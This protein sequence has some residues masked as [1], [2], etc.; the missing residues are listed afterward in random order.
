MIHGT[1][2]MPWRP[3]RNHITIKSYERHYND[4]IMGAIASQIN[5]LTIVY[6]TVYIQ[7]QIKENIKAPRHLALCG[8]FTGEFPAQMAS[9]AEN[10]SIWWRHRVGVSN[11]R[12]LDCLLNSLFGLAIKNI[13]AP[14]CWTFV[15]GWIPSTKSSEAKGVL[16]Y[17]WQI[18]FSL[19]C[20]HQ[21]PFI[22][23]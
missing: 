6:S 23:K 15:S 18:V 12:K 8:E 11:H 16:G 7:A 4:V 10:V 17:V 19:F 21:H 5:S 20:T 22:L 1:M 3:W 9:N 13:R 2:F 14:H